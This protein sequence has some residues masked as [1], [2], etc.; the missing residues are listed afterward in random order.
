MWVLATLGLVVLLSVLFVLVACVCRIDMDFRI[1]GFR[2]LCRDEN[3]QHVFHF[4][5]GD[6]PGY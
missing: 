5:N 6:H 2:I 4:G 1:L 3:G